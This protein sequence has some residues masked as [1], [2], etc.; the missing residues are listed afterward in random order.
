MISKGTLS[1]T[2]KPPAVVEVDFKGECVSVR[3][4][5][6]AVCHDLGVDNE[7]YVEPESGCNLLDEDSFSQ[8]A[9]LA[10]DAFKE[11]KDFIKY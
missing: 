4:F 3:V 5:Q 6:E 10:I 2:V 1:P 8:V 9:S 11:G 7:F